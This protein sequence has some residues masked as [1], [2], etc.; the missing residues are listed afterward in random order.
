MLGLRAQKVTENVGSF[1]YLM[2]ENIRKTKSD[3]EK[4]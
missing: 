3:P 2:Y 1:Q 4:K